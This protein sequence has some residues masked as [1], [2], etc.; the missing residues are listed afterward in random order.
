MP[1]VGTASDLTLQMKPDPDPDRLNADGLAYYAKGLAGPARRCY[2]RALALAPASI[3]ANGNLANLEAGTEDLAQACR[4]Y[5]RALTVAPKLAALHLMLGTAQLRM[6]EDRLGQMTLETAIELNPGYPK[7]HG[8]LGLHALGQ[9]RLPEAEGHFRKALRRDPAYVSALAGLSRVLAELGRSREARAASRRAAALAP[10]SRETLQASAETAF[11]FGDHEAAGR[12]FRRLPASDPTPDA[13]SGL[14]LYLHYDPRVTSEEIHR[15]H[16]RWGGL[17]ASA[18]PRLHANVPVPDRRLK[19]GYLSADLFDH[20]VGRTIVG[21]IENHDRSAVEPFLYALRSED[22]PVNARLRKA[23]GCWRGLAAMSD[24][25]IAGLIRADAIDVLVVL[26]GHTFGNR[27][28]VAARRSAPVQVSMY[29]LTTSGLDAMDWFLSD[30]VLSPSGG[31]ELFSERVMRL[32]CLYLHMPIEADAP[33]IPKNRAI[34]FGSCN[35]PV[36]LND[37]VI[38]LW[39]RILE[40]CPGARLHLKYRD[41]FAD[42]DLVRGV[43]RRFASHGVAATRLGFDGRRSS[44][45][46]HLAYVAGFDVALDPF[47]FNGATTTYEALWMGVPVV[48]LRGERFVGRFG[49]AML[50][51]VGLDDLVAGDDQAYVQAAVALAGDAQ[52]RAALRFEL[53]PRLEASPLLGPSTYAR[54]VEAAYRTMWHEW[55]ART[56]LRPR[57]QE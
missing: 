7:A 31:T 4:R 27:V 39:A 34:V 24:E 50:H 20:P 26:A 40:R 29:D 46:A 19:I 16:R 30:E 53:R 37:R 17:Q 11:L 22:D 51:Q 42:P 32:P 10:G 5:R 23:A 25:A 41:S 52:R 2:R 35:N 33:A 13:L 48:T 47:P 12:G 57:V 44:R 43:E 9:R 6:G 55:C 14:M 21:L 3:E 1:V 45:R 49:A 54:N 56:E 38:S 18:A 36:K 28:A 8:N 15:V